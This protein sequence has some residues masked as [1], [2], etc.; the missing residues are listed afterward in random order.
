VTVTPHPDPA[1]G[2]IIATPN[3]TSVRS[4]FTLRFAIA[5]AAALAAAA[6]LAPVA[7]AILAALG[8]RFPFPR[9]FDRTV[10]VTLLAA[11]LIGW[12][13]MRFGALMRAGFAAP[14]ANLARAA[15]GL[16]IALAAIAT[17]FALARASGA[18]GE[19]TAGALAARAIRFVL[20]AILIG[21]IEEGFFRAFLLGGMR[22]DFGPRGALTVSSALYAVA[23]LVRSPKHYYLTGFHAGAGL[24]DL[25]ASVA[26][27]GHPLAAAPTLIGLFLLGMVLGEAFLLTGTVWFS[28]GMHAGF[29]LGAKTWPLIGNGGAPVPRWIAGPGPV[30]LIAAPAAWLIALALLWLMPRFLGADSTANRG[31][32]RYFDFGG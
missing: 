26:Q 27:L 20:P 32:R 9:I 17:L 8:M 25:A 13:A 21:I 12:R 22:S 30:P 18:G 31:A 15:L 28:L 24:R 2:S 19:V 7:A 10:M 5:L 14:R 23:H 3:R 11:L 1:R 4:S 6:I 16:A 29:V